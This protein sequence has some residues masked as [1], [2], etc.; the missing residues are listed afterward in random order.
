MARMYD[1][2]H[3]DINIK[4][5]K[6]PYIYRGKPPIREEN[7][8]SVPT[9]RELRSKVAIM[10]SETLR[11]QVI[12]AL[13]VD[14][15]LVGFASEAFPGLVLYFPPEIEALGALYAQDCKEND[16][17]IRDIH[18]IKKSMNGWI[19]PPRKRG[20]QPRVVKSKL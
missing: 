5:S 8:S 14:E 12:I 2:L 7:G 20:G 4:N 13:E 16:L 18:R 17:A 10:F 1:L 9:E 6:N 3:K 11:E 19:V 15:N